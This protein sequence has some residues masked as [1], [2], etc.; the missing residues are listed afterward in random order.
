MTAPA[1]EQ[2]RLTLSDGWLAG[3]VWLAVEP[4]RPVVMFIHGFGSVRKGEK[5]LALQAACARR[6]WN[7]AAFDFRGHGDSSG[8]MLDLRPSGLLAD[9]DA[10]RTWLVAHGVTTVYPVGSSMGGWAAAWFTLL[11]PDTVPACVLLAPAFYWLTSR[12]SKLTDAERALWKQTGRHRVKTDWVEAELGFG[13]AEERDR[14]PFQ[15]LITEWA[16]PLLIFHGMQDNVIPYAHSLYFAEQA[17]LP[18]VE[19]HLFKDGDHRLTAHKDEIA[20]AA[21]GF[22]AAHGAAGQ[23]A[24]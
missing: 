14:Y 4:N 2:V 8:T 13:L 7:F 10:I 24:G 9:L 5:A 11:H 15:Q 17:K 12:W 23:A 1:Y 21:C 20:E 19:L 3:D 6:G 18:G 22:F 16:K